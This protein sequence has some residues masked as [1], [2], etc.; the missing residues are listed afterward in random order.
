MPLID[1]VD[2]A[3]EL[4]RQSSVDWQHTAEAGGYVA[5]KC[6][7]V[8]GGCSPQPITAIEWDD[9]RSNPYSGCGFSSVSDLL[10]PILLNLSRMS[11]AQ[12]LHSMTSPLG[13]PAGSPTR[14]SDDLAPRRRPATVAGD[15]R[16]VVGLGPGG[17]RRRG[18]AGLASSPKVR[19][20]TSSGWGDRPKSSVPFPSTMASRCS[21]PKSTSSS[22]WPR[23]SLPQSVKSSCRLL[24]VDPERLRVATW[25]P[26]CRRRRTPPERKFGADKRFTAAGRGCGSRT[27]SGSTGCG[28]RSRVSAYRAPRPRLRCGSREGC[29]FATEKTRTSATRRPARPDKGIASTFVRA[30]SLGGSTKWIETSPELDRPYGAGRGG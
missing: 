18:P 4:C 14:R 6:G 17:S 3:N 22:W 7:L 19:R 27:P 28:K 9:R 5:H 10:A 13:P 8:A 23:R 11:G 16:P 21:R 25:K 29:C 15:R 30:P 12:D 1:G 2:Y 20:S 26:R 24:W